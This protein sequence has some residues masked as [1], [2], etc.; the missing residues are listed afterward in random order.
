MKF[1]LQQ[2][3][4]RKKRKNGNSSQVIIN[5]KGN[6]PKK[7]RGLGH[8]WLGFWKW[9][10]LFSER[11]YYRKLQA[12]TALHLSPFQWGSAKWQSERKKKMDGYVS[13]C[14][15]LNNKLHKTVV[16]TL[17]TIRNYYFKPEE[18]K[19]FHHSLCR[20]LLECRIIIGHQC[21]SLSLCFF[22]VLFNFFSFGKVHQLSHVIWGGR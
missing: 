4:K 7:W 11:G 20:F 16:R 1:A 10:N 12:W 2:E 19:G 21:V 3:F 22:L 18:W 14:F 5:K 6:L 13:H 17:A 9:N 15:D 8:I